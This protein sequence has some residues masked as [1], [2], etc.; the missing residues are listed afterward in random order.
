MSLRMRLFT[1]L[2]GHLVGK[3]EMGNLYY[4]EKN[5]SSNLRKRRWVMFK[6]HAEGSKIS[7]AWHGWIHYVNDVI[8]VEGDKKLFWQKA[9]Q[10][11]TTGTS[12]VYRPQDYLSTKQSTKNHGYEPWKP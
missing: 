12:K 4:E 10:P 1:W 3:D 11:N 5:N 9:H 2:K 8:P 6:G 7:A